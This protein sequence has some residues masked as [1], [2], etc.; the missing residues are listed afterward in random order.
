MSTRA[1]LPVHKLGTVRTARQTAQSNAD[2]ETG[3]YGHTAPP[4]RF[5]GPISARSTPV[6]VAGLFHPHGGGHWKLLFG[7]CC[8]NMPNTMPNTM[9]LQHYQKRA[10]LTAATKG[11]PTC[12]Y[13]HAAS[14]LSCAVNSAVH[15]P[16]TRAVGTALQN[17]RNVR[18]LVF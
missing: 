5:G 3:N 6:H 12:N 1:S 16:P 14:R 11:P 4:Y 10:V 17:T 2:G 13:I 15:Q 8:P 18:G 9:P 7:H